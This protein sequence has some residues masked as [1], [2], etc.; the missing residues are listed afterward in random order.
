M[1]LKSFFLPIGAAFLMPLAGCGIYI[2]TASTNSWSD[3]DLTAVTNVVETADIPAS[4]TDLDV[5]NTFGTVR[6]TGTDSG[7]M[8]W[9]W[10]LNI[11]AR[12]EAEAQQIASE[13]TCSTNLVG[14]RLTLAVTVPNITQPHGIQSDFEI[15]VPKA[16]SA[17]TR[18]HFG[19]TAIAQLNGN[20]EASARNGRVEIHNV[21]GHVTA[22]TT[23]DSLNVN[24][25]GPAVLKDQN[26][27]IQ[28][29]RIAGRLDAE[30]SFAS[31]LAQ[32]IGGPAALINRN[33]SVKAAG[34]GGALG[35]RTSFDSISVR[36][37]HGAAS[38]TN[39]NGRVE[40]SS[41]GGPLETRTSFDSV[42]AHDIA[43]RVLVLNRNGRIE[44]ARARGDADVRTSFDRLS[45]EDIDGSATLANQNGDI[46][47][48]GVTG[49]VKADTSF[50]TLS[51]KGAGPEFICH[52]RN[53][54]IRLHSTSTTI[55]NIEASTSFDNI[56]VH[57][58][59]GLKPAIVAHTSFGDVQSDFPVVMKPAGQSAFAEAEPAAMHAILQ[60]QNG[61]I[62]VRRD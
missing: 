4:L 33:G 37:I 54:A 36:D 20:V 51:I 14:G 27:E 39:Q 29:I 13:I 35:V 34:I 28:A 60:N 21:S 30:T 61:N 9:T 44:I 58:P 15:T 16:A 62:R 48:G 3:A 32:E 24:D 26:G 31:L 22:G 12:T 40:A 2:S 47:A 7:P 52:N 50:A 42:I 43:G 41:I 59:A 56:E 19:P 1:K 25:T 6:V 57:L 45:V 49:T 18:N 8:R 11:R 23:F 17:R 55:T 5:D 38:L 53:G 46:E 10:K